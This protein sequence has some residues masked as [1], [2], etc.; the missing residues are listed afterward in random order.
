MALEEAIR[1]WTSDT[2]QLFGIKDRGV[3]RAGA[4]AD[5]N[6]IDLDGLAIDLPEYRH[7]FP[8]GAGRYVQTGA[9]YDHVIV[10]GQSFMESG[11]HVGSYAG[12]TLR[13]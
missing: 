11:E 12:V 13:S 8:G 1:G 9:G 7:D 4:F 3:L 10:N 5:I 6:V 2:A